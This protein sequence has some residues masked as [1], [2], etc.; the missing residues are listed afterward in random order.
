MNMKLQNTNP[1]VA[2][3]GASAHTGAVTSA[4]PPHTGSRS[5]TWRAVAMLGAAL[6]MSACSSV[7]A[8]PQAS[9]ER[10][11]VLDDATPTA[12]ATAS[13]IAPT[14]TAPMV[15][16]T[17]ASA[18]ATTGTP[19]RG[20]ALATPASAITATTAVTSAALL[21]KSFTDQL[22]RDEKGRIIGGPF[23][24]Y[25]NYSPTMITGKPCK[26]VTKWTWKVV[27]LNAPFISYGIADDPCVIQN[28]VDD[29][30]RTEFANP[31]VNTPE[32]MPT[33]EA[34]YAT[35]KA[36]R[37]GLFDLIWQSQLEYYKQGVTPYYTCDKPRFKLLD[38]NGRTPLTGDK[39]GKVRGQTIVLTVF[40]VAQDVQPFKCILRRYKDNSIMDTQIKTEEQLKGKQQVVKFT[41]LWWPDFKRWR[42]IDLVGV[43]ID[44]YYKAAKAVWDASPLKP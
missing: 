33:V 22:P 14:T 10:I 5:P 12:K 41:M 18:T 11:S 2:R 13:T 21:P 38:V 17:S 4:A 6:L 20:G 35:D 26:R 39:D 34:A 24:P 9:E 3:T 23:L 31:A 43:P 29:F 42:L 32:T 40:I 7:F 8:A 44:H 25:L 16:S 36:I 15:A 27:K 28:A 37:E 19:L 30:V 1:T